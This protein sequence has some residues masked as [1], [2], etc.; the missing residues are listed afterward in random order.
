MKILVVSGFLGAGKTT[1]IKELIK[2]TGIHPVILENE[3]GQN[4]LDSRDL[5]KEK[6]LQVVEFMEGCVCCTTRD[7][8]IN[9]VLTVSAALDPDYL[10]VEPSGIGR[11]SN[12]IGSLNKVEYE[13]IQILRPVVIVSLK[14]LHQNSIKWPEIFCDQIKAAEIL[15][16]SKTENS[17]K[18]ELEAAVNHILSVN[19]S[20]SIIREHYTKAD[21]SIWNSLLELKSKTSDLEACD[22]RESIQQIS[23][24]DAHLDH[25][26][27]LVMLLEKIARGLFGDVVRAKG[28][29]SVGNTLLRFDLADGLYAVSGS[30]DKKIQCTFIGNVIDAE[31]LCN[32][33]NATVLDSDFSG[34]KGNR[35]KSDNKLSSKTN[36]SKINLTETK[37]YK[38]IYKGTLS[39]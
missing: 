36:R 5:A 38:S 19:P 2:R 39:R 20:I 12:I 4:N 17:S 26:G 15:F 3:Y 23:V 22:S 8:F 14:S 6:D 28:V 13:R 32:S 35:K 18:E 7:G 29:L 34:I 27:E 11:L 30:E 9:S 24:Y 1:F 10:I 25:P 37:Q 33:F 21:G 31:Y 16:L